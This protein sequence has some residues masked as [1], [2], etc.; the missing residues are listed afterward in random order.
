M[1]HDAYTRKLNESRVA[2]G[3]STPSAR[4]HTHGG[5][6]AP[7][8]SCSDGSSLPSLSYCCSCSGMVHAV[9][10]LPAAGLPIAFVSTPCQQ[11]VDK[12]GRVGCCSRRRS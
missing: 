5:P 4:H 11:L 3:G 8:G 6:Y 10:P 7:R 1:R 9:Q 12:L 2:P